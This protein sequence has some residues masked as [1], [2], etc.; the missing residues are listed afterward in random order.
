PLD[1]RFLPDH[2]L[3]HR[4]HQPPDQRAVLL[5]EPV[6][7]LRC[8]VAHEPSWRTA[9]PDDSFESPLRCGRAANPA[10]TAETRCLDAFLTVNNGAATRPEPVHRWATGRL[11][12][13]AAGSVVGPVEVHGGPRLLDRPVTP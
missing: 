2:H 13:S 5:D 9:P 10:P 4:V 11:I 6:D 1:H 12:R 7:L 8:H 3:L